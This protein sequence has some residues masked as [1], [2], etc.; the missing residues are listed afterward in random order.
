[1]TD[2]SIVVFGAGAIGS[3]I[4]GSLARAGNTV[5]IVD[6]WFQNDSKMK[7]QGLTVC[8]P[9]EEFV[10]PVLALHLDELDRLPR[11]IDVLIVAVKSYDTE[12]TVR[13]ME[14]YISHSTWIVSAQNGMN[15][16]LLQR[17]V[18]P[19]QIVGCVITMAAEMFEPAVTRRTTPMSSSACI[20]GELDGAESPR[21]QSLAHLMSDVGV[22]R[23]TQNIWGDLWS[24]LCLNA[25][26]NSTCGLTGLTPRQLWTTPSAVALETGLAAECILV[27]E[28]L[29]LRLEPVLGGISPQTIRS[30]HEGDPEAASAVSS[31]IQLV[32]AERVGKNENKSSLL[33]DVLKGRR[34]EIDYLN[35]YVVSRGREAGIPT[36]IN[37]AMVDLIH[38]IEE[39]ALKPNPANIELIDH[40]AAR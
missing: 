7:S 38:R 25:M 4:G 13:L 3:Y 37:S 16:E 26:S 14:H 36:P 29:G 17:L 9:D 33:V 18:D 11:Q 12:W 5:T 6:P 1:M 30:A 35:G 19:A 39:G 10:V 40:P 32:A 21:V 20:L 28:A 23:V 31:A 15:E 24:K 8:A 22:V 2:A 34:T 27:A